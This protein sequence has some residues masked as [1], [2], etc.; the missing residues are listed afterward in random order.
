MK[1]G[2]QE[3]AKGE[4]VNIELIEDEKGNKIFG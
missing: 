3:K 2:R 1:N 4:E